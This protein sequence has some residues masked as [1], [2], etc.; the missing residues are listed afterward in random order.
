MNSDE[1]EKSSHSIQEAPID[2]LQM[3]HGTADRAHGRPHVLIIYTGGTIG[4]V[5]TS[6]GY[7][8]K[9]GYLTKMVP[10]ILRIDE[11]NDGRKKTAWRTI[12]TFTVVEYEPLLDS[13]NQTPA[14]WNRIAKHIYDDYETADGFI[15]IHGTDTMTYTAAA[16]SFALQNLSKPIVVTGAQI[17]LCEL[18]TDA[19]SNLIGALQVASMRSESV[20]EVCIFFN[21]ILMR[22]N[23]SMKSS[24]DSM[25][26]F[27]SPSYPPLMELGIN[28]VTHKDRYLIPPS[29]PL[30]LN[31]L[32]TDP[33]RVA[34]IKL[35]PGILGED[36][37]ILLEPPVEAAIVM[38][39]GIGNAPEGIL[40]AIE[41]A[42]ARGVVIFNVSQCP[43]G[44]V[45]DE[46][47]GTG[48]TL[49][50]AGVLSAKGMTLEACYSKLLF[51]IERGLPPDRLKAMMGVDYAGEITAEGHRI[52]L[53][54][55]LMVDARG[56]RS[57][58]QN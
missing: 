58:D 7:T 53:R 52:D 27:T 47:F 43:E 48:T 38:T 44:L 45:D 22:G 41:N 4:M 14:N 3:D 10:E 16:L 25:E 19:H 35:W 30:R 55:H 49:K 23:R 37:A 18:R 39:F 9:R 13:S 31:V 32:N 1:S 12:P 56:A 42:I 21:G 29:G 50:N 51:L 6:R 36:M 54:T 24:S 40:A 8:P 5:S 17:P 2:C 34:V 15:V 57:V 26:G 33:N 28:V 46:A 11:K 20:N